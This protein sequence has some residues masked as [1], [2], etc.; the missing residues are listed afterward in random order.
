MRYRRVLCAAGGICL[1]NRS[2]AVR[3]R[4]PFVSGPGAQGTGLPAERTPEHQQHPA[5]FSRRGIC[6]CVGGGGLHSCCMAASSGL[7]S[8]ERPQ[9]QEESRV[10]APSKGEIRSERRAFFPVKERGQ[11]MN[12]AT[13]ADRE[14]KN[15]TSTTHLAPVHAL[16]KQAERRVALQS[17]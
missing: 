16:D 5:S 12:H 17:S 6:V 10:V 4:G 14:K 9:N 11:W 13:T 3:Q 1:V 15:K 7:T 8:R 2:E